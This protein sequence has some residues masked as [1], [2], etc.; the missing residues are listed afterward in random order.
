MAS[1]VTNGLNVVS[2]SAQITILISHDQL[3]SGLVAELVEQRCSVPEVAG[4]SPTRVGDFSL[5]PCGPISL[6]GLSLRRYYLGY[7]LEHLNLP[8][9][10]HCI[11]A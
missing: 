1:T 6:L 10:H 2:L 8:D 3:Q 5:S 7:L 9:L 4:S 11:D